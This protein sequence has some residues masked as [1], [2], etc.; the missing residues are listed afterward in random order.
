MIMNYDVL[1]FFTEFET[2]YFFFLEHQPKPKAACKARYGHVDGR[3]QM[4]L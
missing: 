3:A 1:S 4:Y 2:Y